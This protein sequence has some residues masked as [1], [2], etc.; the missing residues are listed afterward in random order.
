[1]TVHGVNVLDPLND[2][3]NGIR[4]IR[5]WDCG[6]T[7][8][9]LNPARGVFVWDRLDAIVEGHPKARLMLVLAV[10]PAWAASDTEA[11]SAPWLP[12]GSSSPPKDL[13]DW[14]AYVRAVVT[15]YRGRIAAYQVWNEPQLK[16]FW[17]PYARID[18]LARMTSHVQSIV[19]AHDPAAKVVG[20]PVLPRA[21]SGGMR[22]AE[23]YL[24]ALAH[25]GWPVDVHAA[26]VYPEIGKGATAWG[27]AVTHWKA[28][29]ARA[30]APRKP[31]WVTETNFN[32]MGGPLPVDEQA[33]LVRV[34]DRIADEQ[35]IARCYWYAYGR[36]GDPNVLGIP[37]T[38]GSP[39]MTALEAL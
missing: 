19:R 36:H 35:N 10:T 21:S 12:A 9:D 30:V 16:E 25:A 2:W 11:A 8:A 20:A 22:R 29:L 38:A 26:H 37:F 33:R 23:A 15:R 7:W 27:V 3:P 14:R 32:L 18:I 13:A 31:L 17:Q 1:M 34:T 5:L 24:Q 39:G 6:V 28:G 4:Q